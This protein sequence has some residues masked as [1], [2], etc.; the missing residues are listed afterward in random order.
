M[1]SSS[2]C[3][4]VQ[5]LRGSP[6]L[7]AYAHCHGL[8]VGERKTST[9][10]LPPLRVVYGTTGCPRSQNKGAAVTDVQVLQ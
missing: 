8:D 1:Q 4:P 6:T 2:F 9:F 3:P 10:I 7:H 5:G